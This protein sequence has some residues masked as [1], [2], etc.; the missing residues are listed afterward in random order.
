LEKRGGNN[1]IAVKLTLIL[2]N[3]LKFSKNHDAKIL[4]KETDTKGFSHTKYQIY[5]KGLPVEGSV[6]TIH[7]TDTRIYSANG[8]YYK[9]NNISVTPSLTEQKAFEY[10]LNYINAKQWPINLIFMLLTL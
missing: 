1:K 2:N 5:Y 4:K 9:G 6:Y 10:A 3:L 7:S 8:E